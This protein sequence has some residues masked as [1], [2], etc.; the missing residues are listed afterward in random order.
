MTLRPLASLVLVWQIASLRP[1]CDLRFL[2]AAFFAL[3][4]CT[5]ELRAEDV[6]V[7]ATLSDTTTEVGQPVQ[8]E[9]KVTGA[10]N[11]EPPGNISIDG[12]SIG[13]IS[14]SSQSSFNLINGSVSS[15]SSTTFTFPIVPERAG[16]FTIPALTL[17]ADGK[18]FTTRPLTLMVTGSGSSGNNNAGT[19]TKPETDNKIAFA[20]LIAPKQTAYVGEAIPVEVRVYF[21]ARIR[22]QTNPMPDLKGDGFTVQK[23][24][25][26]QQ[27]QIEKEGKV[28]NFVAFK[29]V[30]TPVK[31]GRLSLGPAEL[32]YV[33]VIPV[34][35]K[36]QPPRMNGFPDF[37]DDPFFNN[38]FNMQEPRQMT[39][40][41]AGVDFEVKPLPIANQPQDFGGAVGQFT[42]VTEAAPKK[43]NAGDPITLTLKI[44]GRGNF[45][46]VAA[47]R[48][49]EENGWRSYPPSGKFTADDDVGISGTKTFE[50]AVI[51]DGKKTRLPAVEFSYFDPVAEKYVTLNAE[52][53][54]ITVEGQSAQP[55]A[56]QSTAPG[57][58]PAAAPE[59]A[60]NAN[61][62][63]YILTGPA[64]W[65]ESFE[66]VFRRRFF[67]D[68]QLAPLLALMAFI[69]FQLRRKRE[70]NALAKQAAE[71]RREKADLMK[72]LQRGDVEPAAF[73]DAAMR[74][75]QI[76]AARRLRQNPAGIG[77]EDAVAAGALDAAAGD[78]VRSIFSA[79]EE[80]SYSG[81]AAR[82]KLTAD[83]RQN[84]LET[85]RRFENADV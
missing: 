31:S 48:M 51:P 4:F 67:W 44:S 16:K 72:T 83:Q 35:R 30:I 73:Y 49:I 69:G 41:S 46:R 22:V 28:Y 12:L 59:T 68:A 84:V 42:L 82:G 6:S 53:L 13:G 11:A 38:A 57:S 61:D 2:I 23:M 76:E 36:I 85:I 77:A 29:T 14:R 3:I 27:K 52:R 24:T 75:I 5:H 66:P 15:S 47:P 20:E 74:A 80:L 32:P 65:G 58:Q 18:K 39:V 19:T 81:V 64:R 43:L 60:K 7:R 33:A 62:I 56:A 79:H 26:S 25:Q 50:M 45:D 37:F 34:K 17:E 21:D 71:L 78:A 8:L 40:K 54:P 9:I 10:H 70:Q 1:A 55:A 63:H